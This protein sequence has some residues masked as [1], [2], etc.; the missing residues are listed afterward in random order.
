[1]DRTVN[2]EAVLRREGGTTGGREE[3]VATREDGTYL[4]RSGLVAITRQRG[5]TGS[6]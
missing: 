4:C 3:T 6:S 5:A 2:L 1:M